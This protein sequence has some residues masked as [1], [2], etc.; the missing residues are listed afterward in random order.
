M[1]KVSLRNVAVNDRL[2]VDIRIESP[3]PD[4]QYRLRIDRGTQLKPKHINRLKE[5][6]VRSVFVVDPATKDLSSYIRDEDLEA[7]ERETIQNLRTTAEALREDNLYKLPA[8]ELSDTIQNLIDTI[9][10][11]SVSMAYSS[12]KSHTD[13]LAKHQFDVCR[14]SLHYV[15]VYQDELIEKYRTEYSQ[16]DLSRDEF[17]EVLGMGTL[18]HDIGNWEIPQE[19][20]EKRKELTDTEWEAIKQHPRLGFDIMGNLDDVNRLAR[21]PALHHHERYSGQG[22]PKGRSGK[23]IHLLGRIAAICD[24]YTALTSERPYR[25]KL[26]PNRAIEIMKDMQNGD[27]KAFEPDLM[28]K[29]LDIM[30]PY[31]IGQ[32]VVLSDGTRGV[33]CGLDEGFETPRVRVLFEENQKLDDYYEIVANVSESPDIL[34]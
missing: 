5:E 26:T 28:Q 3:L 17:T 19:T 31:P 29:F 21:M 4:V 27:E 25:V 13:Y 12:L 32:D 10:D 8:E 24:V 9:K 1:R 6:G 22:Y 14:L 15:L 30:P 33:V 2:A 23:D 20:L 34:N 11:S 16:G 7:V 18:L